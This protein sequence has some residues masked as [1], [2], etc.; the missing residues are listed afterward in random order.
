MSGSPKSKEGATFFQAQQIARTKR[1]SLENSIGCHPPYRK[2]KQVISRVSPDCS[3]RPSRASGLTMA[4]EAKDKSAAGEEESKRTGPQVWVSSA[5]RGRRGMTFY[6]NLTLEKLQNFE[7]VEL[8]GL[9]E[10]VA[11]VVEVA[12]QLGQGPF[13]Q[14]EKIATDLISTQESSNMPK[15]VISLK[16]TKVPADSDLPA[17]S[18]G[19]K[20]KEATKAKPAAAEAAKE[21]DDEDDEEDDED[22]GDE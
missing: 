15:I 22:D 16:R 4:T 10:A 14:V 3:V 20:E 7:H 18:K 9:G 21:D 17:R 1:N 13:C 6:S 2:K 12:Q 19:G 5:Q 8:H 11:V